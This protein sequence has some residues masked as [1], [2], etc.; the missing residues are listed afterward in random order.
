MARP[1]AQ[2]V[3][4]PTTVPTIDR[5]DLDSL[6]D[7]S[8]P[9]LIDVGTSWCG[10]CRLLLPMLERL[11]DETDGS[12]DVVKI[13]AERSPELATRFGVTTIPTL[14]VFSGAELVAR[15][16]GK[17]ARYRELRALVEPHLR[18]A[19]PGSAPLGG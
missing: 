5:H 16:A 7:Q 12:L 9:M 19:E 11:A 14:L 4:M 8:R 13:D 1:L 17:P 18:P 15:R 6:L 10:P 2:P 3:A